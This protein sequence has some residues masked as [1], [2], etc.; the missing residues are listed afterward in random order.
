TYLPTF[1]GLIGNVDRQDYMDTLSGH[2]RLWDSELRD[3]EVLLV[4][5]HPFLHGSETFEG[6]RH[7][8]SFPAQ[9]DTYEGLSLCDTL[10]TDY[11]SVFYDFANAGKKIILFAYDRKEYESGRGMYEDIGSY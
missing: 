1:R 10:I 11:S 9:W 4:K 7:I 6:Y 3:G 2:L 8:R 5:L